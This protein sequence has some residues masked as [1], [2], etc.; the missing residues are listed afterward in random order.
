MS[1]EGKKE[2]FARG[3]KNSQ[4]VTDKQLINKTSLQSVLW[5]KEQI[6]FVC[7]Y[8]AVCYVFFVV[9][10]TGIFAEIL[11]CSCS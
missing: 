4:M 5:G 10:D 1:E 11:D 9:F 3:D 7:M 8:L 6:I 2:K